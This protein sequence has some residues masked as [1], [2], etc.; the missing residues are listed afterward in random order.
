[1]IHTLTAY[2]I[3]VSGFCAW[4]FEQNGQPVSLPNFF[5][6]LYTFIYC[7]PSCNIKKRFL[8]KIKFF[9]QRFRRSR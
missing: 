1:M 2:M 9:I 4:I 8:L 7:D 5:R 6:L 3:L